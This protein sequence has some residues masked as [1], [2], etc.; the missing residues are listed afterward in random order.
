MEE[1]LVSTTTK[2]DSGGKKL[3]YK[4]KEQRVEIVSFSLSL[5]LLCVWGAA[6][7][8]GRKSRGGEEEVEEKGG[9]KK[10]CSTLRPLSFGKFPVSLSSPTLSL[11]PRHSLLDAQGRRRSAAAAAPTRRDER[12]NE[13]RGPQSPRGGRRDR[14]HRGGIVLDNSVALSGGGAGPAPRLRRGRRGPAPQPQAGPGR[15]C[16]AVGF[17]E[18]RG[19]AGEREK[20]AIGGLGEERR[21]D[22]ERDATERG[23]RFFL[24]FFFS[25][26][27]STLL[28][29]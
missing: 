29:H 23:R 22:G 18:A 17:A 2:S 12:E 7:E 1:A 28:F 26:S 20:G 24:S 9:K 16:G 11:L 3:V 8:Q 21:G 5:S 4:K 10:K 19:C 15:D 25:T 6:A 27:T 13:L 14:G